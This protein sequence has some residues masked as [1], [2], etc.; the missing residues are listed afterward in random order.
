VN[1]LHHQA[2]AEPGRGLR[3]VARETS[4]IVQGIEHT[5][6]P[7]V[8]GVQWH[9]EYLPQHRRQRRLFSALVTAAA[10]GPSTGGRVS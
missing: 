2:V 4:G 1:A 8:L 6:L 7:L 10:N 9:P 5:A 3:I